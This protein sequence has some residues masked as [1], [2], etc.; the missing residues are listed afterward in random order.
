MNRHKKPN[1]T[2]R[3]LEASRCVHS[4]TRCYKNKSI[5]RGKAISSLSPSIGD[6][7]AVCDFE[8]GK[9]VTMLVLT[10]SASLEPT[11]K[12]MEKVPSTLYKYV[13]PA[14]IDTLENLKIRFTQ[15]SA[16]NDPFEFNLTFQ[17]IITGKELYDEFLSVDPQ[18][19]IS[20]A[21]DKLPEAERAILSS[22]TPEQ[23]DLLKRQAAQKFF[24]FENMDK[25]RTEHI[26]PHTTAIKEKL[27]SGLDK[28]IG[29]L[30]LS[31]NATIA[32]M[33][34]SYADNSKGFVIGFDTTNIFFQ[35]RRSQSDE[36]YHLRKVIYEDMQPID[37]ISKI[38]TNIL[39]QKNKSWEYEDEWRMLLPLKTANTKITTPEGDE[40]FLFE[41]PAAAISHIIFGLKT[42]DSTIKAVQEA[43]SKIESNTHIKFSKVVKG[44][45]NFAI[46]PL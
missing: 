8:P 28:S 25:I 39:I 37:S 23:L 11:N 5:T 21:I 45:T 4:N 33:W 38:T 41:I 12:N 36:L 43:I 19:R 26:S 17:D 18:Q 40:V 10:P 3:V 22:L 27:K 35:R 13:I 14:R 46:A 7:A 20:E 16:L 24:S 2:G 30:S 9:K 1:S 6:P 29:I 15:P 44:T 32:P 31:A 34:A 42:E